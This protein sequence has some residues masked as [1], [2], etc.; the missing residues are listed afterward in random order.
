MPKLPKKGQTG[1]PAVMSLLE[2]MSAPAL[3]PM[4]QA[5]MKPMAKKMMKNPLYKAM[6]EKSKMAY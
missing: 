5:E 1:N 3:P 4:P 2:K 6:S